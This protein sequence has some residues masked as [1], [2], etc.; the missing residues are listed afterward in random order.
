MH[1]RGLFVLRV[2]YVR[3]GRGC[4]WSGLAWYLVRSGGLGG[5]QRAE[6]EGLSCCVT[7]YCRVAP[8]VGYRGDHRIVSRKFGQ[9]Q[10]T[11][12]LKSSQ[13]VSRSSTIRNVKHRNWAMILSG[14][15][16]RN[17]FQDTAAIV[18]GVYGTLQ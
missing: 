17:L 6:D 12:F 14:N 9:H 7:V 1:Q 4:C 10:M 5:I 13:N 11:R 8:P 16:R 18:I 2:R 3:K 15:R